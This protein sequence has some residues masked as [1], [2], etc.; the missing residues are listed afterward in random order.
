MSTISIRK[1]G[2]TEKKKAEI[3]ELIIKVRN[4]EDEVE[5]YQAV[6]SSI[7]DKLQK[8]QAELAI[9]NANKEQGLA[10]KKLMESIVMNVKD[11]MGDSATVQN[12]MMTSEDKI[13][14]ASSQ[15]SSL[16]NELIYSADLINKLS[17]LIIR[18]KQIN[19]LVSDELVTMVTKAGTDANN[20]VSLTLTALQSIFT[21]QATNVEGQNV[22]KL[23]Q[24]L[25]KEL[26]SL[27]EFKDK[28]NESLNE[29]VLFS[30][31][32][33]EDKQL[34]ISDMIIQ[35]YEY[36]KSIYDSTLA[37]TDDIT[38]QL[39]E[40][41]LQLDDAVVNFNSLKASLAAAQAAALAA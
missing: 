23:E 26:N 33:N 14:K 32:Q 27:I 21:S 5:E 1:Y 6:V 18:K 37:A 15:M 22:L 30:T 28:S 41:T 17:D 7:S 31:T 39:S 19:P 10:N 29:T 9:A 36:Y 20:A 2:V 24:K 38:K 13:K 16:I 34:N 35:A 40:A 3:D 4:A 25:A 11:L 8:F 12:L